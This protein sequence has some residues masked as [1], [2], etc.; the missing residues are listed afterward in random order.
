MDNARIYHL[1]PLVSRTFALSI[2]ALKEPLKL[3]VAHAYLVCRLLDIFEDDP[4]LPLKR[5]REAIDGIQQALKQGC[6]SGVPQIA[7]DLQAPD[8]EQDLVREADDLIA[9]LDRFPGRVRDVIVQWAVE[10]GEG[11]KQY[12][13]SEATTTLIRTMEDLDRY[14][15]YVAGTVGYMLT[16]LFLLYGKHIKPAARAVLNQ[17]KEAFGKALQMVNVIKDSTRDNQEKRCF[18][19][20]DLFASQHITR[21]EFFGGKK[22]GAIQ[23]VYNTLISR[24]EG[25]LQDALK[26]TLALPKRC[27][28]VRLFCI[29]PIVLAR[30]TLDLIKQNVA[31]LIQYP[32]RVKLDRKT[33]R[34][35]VRR[36]WLA[37]LSNGYLKKLMA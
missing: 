31:A 16:D 12:A 23:G 21:Q 4:G 6:E 8:A 13:F 18:V 1:L 29:I 32:G 15:Y 34:K 35:L 5:K 11:M 36:C 28:S 9:C 27:F 25:Y 10:M 3:W 2:Q 26:Y 20:Q 30:K 19:P 22:L 24:A 37:A 33:V 14:C 7:D 17:N